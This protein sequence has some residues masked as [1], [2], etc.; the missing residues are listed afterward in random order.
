MDLYIGINGCSLKT[1]E[2]IDN[3]QY[4]PLDKMM[5]ETDSPYCGISSKHESYQYLSEETKGMF[6]AKIHKKYNS[7][8]M[9]KR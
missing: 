1:K 5:I 3:L 7:D 4:I 8:F 2:N 6:K 9:V